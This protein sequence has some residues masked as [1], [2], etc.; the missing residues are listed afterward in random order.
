MLSYFCQGV[1]MSVCNHYNYTLIMAKKVMITTFKYLLRATLQRK[2]TFAY[3]IRL[4]L[5]LKKKMFLCSPFVF[6]CVGVFVLVV[7]K[8]CEMKGCL[9]AALDGES[10]F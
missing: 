10:I 7:E 2:K 5:C 3:Q 6:L 8:S 9:S 1:F 4:F